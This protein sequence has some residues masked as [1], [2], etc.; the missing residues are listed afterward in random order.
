MP[1]EEPNLHTQA[2]SCPDASFW[3]DAKAYDAAVATG[4]PNLGAHVT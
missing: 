3:E 1:G 2:M 4:L